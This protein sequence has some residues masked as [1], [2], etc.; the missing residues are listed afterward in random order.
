MFVTA[1]IRVSRS[2]GFSG[3]FVR[4]SSAL[5]TAQRRIFGWSLLSQ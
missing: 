4:S 5:S 1:A 3:I 2:G